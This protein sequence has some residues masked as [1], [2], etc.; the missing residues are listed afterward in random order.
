M[1]PTMPAL[2]PGGT[3]GNRLREAAMLF[4]RT[5]ACVLGINIGGWDTHTNQG[6][7]VGGPRQQLEQ[8]R[9]RFR[10]PQR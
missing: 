1:S 9:R 6:G 7:A 2:Y 5:D 3:F 4:K 10:R 8:L